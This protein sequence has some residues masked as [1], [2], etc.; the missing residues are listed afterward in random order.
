MKILVTMSICVAGAMGLVSCGGDSPG[1]G[2]DGGAG[3]DGGGDGGDAAQCTASAGLGAE[4]QSRQVAADGGVP[5]DQLAYAMA[6]ARCSYWRRC[7]G[8]AT[9]VANE[10][11]DSLAGSENWSY[12]TCGNNVVGFACSWGGVHYTIPNAALLQAVA[13]GVI[14]YDAQLEGQCVAALMAQGCVSNAL[15]EDIPVCAG[16]FTCAVGSDDGGSG[17][18]DGGASDAGSACSQFISAY[19]KPLHTCSTDEDCAGVSG[20]LEGPDCV[21][22]ICA[23]TRCGIYLSGCTSFAAAG[24]PCNANAISVLNDVA[25]ATPGGTCAPGLACQGA[26]TDGGLGTCVVPQ[27]VGGTCTLDTNCKPGLVCAC[28]ACEIPPS[29]GPCVNG[30]CQVGVA[31]CDLGTNICRAVRPSGASCAAAINSCGPGLVC[32]GGTC[33]PLG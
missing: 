20:Y 14:R 17:P 6:V 23:A 18:T 21:A 31:Y 32:N 22:G 11:I 15:L 25:A 27:D 3:H 29:T 33:G 10:C 12:Q 30:L 7:F 9:Y 24:Q 28:G 19:N 13:A 5:I 4:P 2:R 8:L 1:G 16:V 26:T